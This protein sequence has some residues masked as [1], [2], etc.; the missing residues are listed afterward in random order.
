MFHTDFLIIRQCL[1]LLRNKQ[2]RINHAFSHG[3][4]YFYIYTFICICIHTCMRRCVCIHMSLYMHTYLHIRCVYVYMYMHKL[5]GTVV[6]RE[7]VAPWAAHAWARP[8]TASNGFYASWQHSYMVH[9]AQVQGL[10]M[11]QKPYKI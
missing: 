11:L 10:S 8:L 6:Q 2:R 3:D 1:Y 4:R 5:R 9:G 7:L